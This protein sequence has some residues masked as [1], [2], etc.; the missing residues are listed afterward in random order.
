ME[1]NKYIKTDFAQRLYDPNDESYSCGNCWGEI[2]SSD[3][4]C[5]HCE[6]LIIDENLP[7]LVPKEV[8]ERSLPN[9]QQGKREGWHRKMKQRDGTNTVLLQQE[10][11]KFE[12]R[13]FFPEVSPQYIN[14][15]S[16]CKLTNSGTIYRWGYAVP[17]CPSCRLIKGAK[18][19]PKKR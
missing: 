18:G 8:R 1:R 10:P 19:L 4:I 14:H 13:S 9:G 15:C 5:P 16:P 3:K 6:I 11:D 2:N 17:P 7:N 12:N